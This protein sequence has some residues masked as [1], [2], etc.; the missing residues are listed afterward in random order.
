MKSYYYLRLCDPRTY[1]PLEEY[2]GRAGVVRTRDL[3]GLLTFGTRNEAGEYVDAH[4]N[5][6]PNRI[7]QISYHIGKDQLGGNRAIVK[8]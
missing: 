5:S 6:Y 3:D 1:L 8:I 2:I 7:I 4:R